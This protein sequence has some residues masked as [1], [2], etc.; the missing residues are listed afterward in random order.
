MLLQHYVVASAMNWI[1][2]FIKMEFTN[3]GSAVVRYLKIM[4]SRKRA[5]DAGMGSVVKLWNSFLNQ[6]HGAGIRVLGGRVDVH[7]TEVKSNNQDNIDSRNTYIRNAQLD[8]QK[9]ISKI[10]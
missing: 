6:N 10:T 2:P 9:H 5:I 1:F 7:Q 8:L 3:S 4:N